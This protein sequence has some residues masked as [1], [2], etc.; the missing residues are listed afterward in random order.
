MPESKPNGALRKPILSAKI[1]RTIESAAECAT[2]PITVDL[3]TGLVT[4]GIPPPA[5]A[6]TIA[7]LIW[8]RQMIAY[9]A[10]K[11]GAR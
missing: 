9:R 7:A 6:D 5:Y 3:K 1:L 2:L 8:A 10:A 4:Y 11:K